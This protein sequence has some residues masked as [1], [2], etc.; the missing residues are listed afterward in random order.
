MKNLSTTR[1][2]F[3]LIEL[4]VVIAIIAILAAILFPVFAQ[5]REKARQT[6]CLS[7]M[8]QIGLGLMMYL[9]DYDEVLP[10]A[11]SYGPYNAALPSLTSPYVQKVQQYG[12][13]TATNSIWACP[14]DAT[15]RLNGGNPKQS[16][17][18][19]F[20]TAGPDRAPWASWT[21]AGTGAYIAG[22]SLAAFSS[23]ADTFLLAE[24]H[25]DEGILGTNYVG[26]KRPFILA[27]DNQNNAF[28][29]Q[30]CTVTSNNRCTN[31]KNP[32]HSLSW[33]YVFADGHAKSM[34]PEATLGK[35]VGGNGL[36]ATGSPCIR[37]R[38]CGPWTLD[39]QD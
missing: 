1:R 21:A 4:L 6:A 8:K 16:Y 31:L 27:T 33:N 26:V 11:Q 13:Q 7:N 18:A 5:A 10:M 30:N 28:N 34:R 12:T 39:D 25:Q 19:I 35:G 17:A 24:A 14:S 9:Q 20:W 2:A 3:T 38:P 23:P 37:T 29:A 15:P 36:D 22:K 32:A